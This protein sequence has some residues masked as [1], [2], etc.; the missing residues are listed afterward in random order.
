MR[1]LVDTQMLLWHLENDKRLSV[2]RG[3]YIEDP[4]N[5]ILVSIASLWE[6]GIK[7]SIKKLSLV[8]PLDSIFDHIERSTSSI[9]PIQPAHIIGVS[10]LPLHHRDPFDRLIISQALVENVP[11]LSSDGV[12]HKYGVELL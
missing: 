7:M 10:K 4:A 1:I 6:I 11:V 9:L 5:Q 2:S 8:K 3:E 12:F